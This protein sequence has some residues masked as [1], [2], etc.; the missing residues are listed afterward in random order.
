MSLDPHH[1]HNFWGVSP[2]LDLRDVVRRC[3][4]DQ[5]TAEEEAPPDASDAPF[6]TLLVGTNDPRHIVTTLAR[7][8]RHVGPALGERSMT[9]HVYE[10]SMVE[11]ARHVLLLCVL[12]SDDLPPSERVERFLEIFMNATLRESTAELVETCAARLER[13]VGAMFAG[14][15]DAPDIAN[16]RVCRVFDFSLLKFKEKDELMECFRSWRA[17]PRARSAILLRDAFRRRRAARRA[18]AEVLRRPLRPPQERGG[19]GL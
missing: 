14:E 10:S 17:D 19:L 2:A 11:A 7:A 12:M 15:A 18:P 1:V 13:V 4:A 16:D 3:R 5:A 9:F 8:R 6:S